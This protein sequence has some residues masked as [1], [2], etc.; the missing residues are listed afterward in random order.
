MVLTSQS[1][2]WN[3]LDRPETF[4][5]YFGHHHFFTRLSSKHVRRIGDSDDSLGRMLAVLRFWF[6]KDL[7]SIHKGSR[8]DWM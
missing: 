7:V 6:T 3:Y 1:E 4:I 5:G 8:H 2:Y